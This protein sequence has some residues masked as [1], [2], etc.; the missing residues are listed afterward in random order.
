MGR[1]PVTLAGPRE[2]MEAAHAAIQVDAG[3]SGA[4]AVVG[5]HHKCLHA[6]GD[7]S[8]HLLSLQKS[9]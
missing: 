5:R 9:K 1:T 6:D 7:H 4:H 3:V 8:E 2:E